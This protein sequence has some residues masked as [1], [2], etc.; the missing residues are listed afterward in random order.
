MKK[1][2]PVILL[3]SIS[4]ILST[5]SSG[6]KSK[7]D[8]KEYFSLGYYT[9][10]PESYDAITKSSDS[11]SAVSADLYTVTLLGDLTNNDIPKS[12][13]SWDK[14]HGIKTYA[15]VSNYG[16][17]DFDSDIAHAAIVTYPA[18][19]ISLITALAEKGSFDGVNLDF[20]GI[21]A[22]DRGAYS[23]FVVS[24]AKI[25]HEKNMQLVIS[26]PAKESDDPAD[27]WSGAF[28]FSVLGKN[29]DYIQLMTYDEHGIW[30]D[31]TGSVAGLPW[32][33]ECVAYAIS[34]IPA[35]KVLIGLPAYG[36]DWDLT[37]SSN[38][39][40][41]SWKYTLDI[42]TEYGAVEHWDTVSSSPWFSYTD[43]NGHSHIAWHENAKSIEA[44][45][46]VAKQYNLAGISMWSLGEEDESFW[47][48]VHSAW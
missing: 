20:E 46:A 31:D 33:T 15:C 43:T 27:G 32:V 45:T 14:A 8:A 25:L 42:Q 21:P 41:F 2:I 35:A 4:L 48:A 1:C 22:D 39:T 38:S 30:N 29:A 28:D 36:Y 11:L 7:S 47:D 44:K 18:K 23:A 19:V 3:I 17:S 12:V 13:L 26:V 16:K 40:S 10:S 6:N 5:C 9:N 37:D 34:V 24:I